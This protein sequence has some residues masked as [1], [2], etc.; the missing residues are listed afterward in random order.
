[1][2]NNFILRSFLLPAS[3]VEG[4]QVPENILIRPSMST[5]SPAEFRQSVSTGL[6]PATSVHIISNW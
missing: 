5:G 6:M 1:V 2:I 3:D 4:R